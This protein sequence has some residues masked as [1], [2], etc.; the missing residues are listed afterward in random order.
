LGV[1]YCAQSDFLVDSQ[2]RWES[3]V[4]SEPL[5]NIKSSSDLIGVQTVFSV[6]VWFMV[7]I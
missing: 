6:S 2:N 1:T 5:L 3:R 4:R 7:S